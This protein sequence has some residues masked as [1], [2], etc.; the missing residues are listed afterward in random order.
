MGRGRRLEGWAN[1]FH[2]PADYQEEI[3]R[4]E[5]SGEEPGDC[6]RQNKN[7]KM[8]WTLKSFKSK[9]SDFHDNCSTSE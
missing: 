7:K 8:S 2:F 9:R 6:L 5:P 4:G 3:R 1:I